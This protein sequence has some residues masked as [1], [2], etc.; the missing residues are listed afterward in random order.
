MTSMLG[1]SGVVYRAC[2]IACTVRVSFHYNEI[3]FHMWVMK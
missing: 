1:I 3:T 2:N